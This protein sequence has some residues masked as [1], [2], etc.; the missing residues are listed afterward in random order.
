VILGFLLAVAV[1]PGYVDPNLCRGCHAE[2]AQKFAKT[3]MGRSFTRSPRPVAGEFFHR[4]SNRHYRVSQRDGRWYMRR[5]QVDARGNETN[6]IE[7][8]IDFTIGSGN[9]AE[10]YV[11]RTAQ[12]RLTQLPLSRYRENGGFWAM[13]PGY[14]R[15]DHFDFR[16][17]V[18]DDC[19]FC[20]NGYPAV[21]NGGVAEGID[22]QRCHGPGEAHVRKPSR[23]TIYGARA[24]DEVCFQ[25][26]LETVSQGIPNAVRLPGR[27]AF[28]YRPGTPLAEFKLHF[29]IPGND[30]FE[31]NHAAYRMRQSRCAPLQCATCHEP[32]HAG[33]R[34]ASFRETCQG[35]HLF[36][37]AAETSDCVAC[38]MAKRRTQDAVHVVMTDHRIQRHVPADALAPLREA[39]R[40][41]TGPLVAYLPAS[42]AARHLAWA[43]VL[44]RNN[45]AAGIPALE[46]AAPTEVPLRLALADAYRASGR[47][48]DALRWYRAAGQPGPLGE[49]LLRAGEVDKAIPML[50][51]ARS[52]ATLGVAYGQ[53]GRIADSVRVL[54]RA[55]E[56]NPDAPVAWLNLGV[57]LEKHGDRDGAGRAYREAIRLQPD[58]G[59]AKVRLAALVR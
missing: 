16:R 2:I 33:P 32:H 36:G 43:Q 47:M 58:F 23:A 42:I 38:H 19:L 52:W 26:H 17:E 24:S 29:D 31:I 28:S 51:A 35:C 48:E 49:A 41:Y 8:S 25:C 34:K 50:E 15:P 59:E 6:V 39:H 7:R 3:G 45:L 27:G 5:H 56:E 40:P 22:C 53:R 4:A 14:D 1:E 9:H 54:R 11:H 55:V 21:W 57:S 10:T 13:S 44:E 20:H 30:H 37:H 18:S 46:Q 12:G